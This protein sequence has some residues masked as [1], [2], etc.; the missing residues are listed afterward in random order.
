MGGGGSSGG[1]TQQTMQNSNSTN[2][3]GPNPFIAPQLQ[4]LVNSASGWM[5]NNMN[6]P[7]YFPGGTVAAQTPAAQSARD[8]TWGW[9]TNNLNNLQGQFA[10]ATGYLSDAASGKFLDV[11][12]DPYWQ[13]ALEASFRPQSEQFRDILAPSI[14]SKF[15]GS[16]RTAG[17][18]HFDTTMRG[19][20]DLERSQSDSAAKAAADRYNAERGYQSGA[21]QALPGVLGQMG[22]QA[23]NWLQMLG[24]VGAGDTANEQRLLDAQNAK[25]GYDTS[26]QLDWY[27]RLSQT[28]Q[29]MYPGGQTTGQQSGTSQSMGQQQQPGGGAGS[30]LGPAM[31]LAG[32]GLMFF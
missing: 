16:G 24:G 11:A 8:S 14:D 19:V 4:N 22:G 25:Y 9:A 20:Q 30:F 10:P 29:S 5:G 13:K 7:G 17:G 18:A 26:G 21:A 23:Q 6:A 27:N 31:S 32:T 15:A 12:N 2:T 28:L 3:S 1:G